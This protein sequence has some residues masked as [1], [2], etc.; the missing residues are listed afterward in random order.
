MRTATPSGVNAQVVTAGRLRDTPVHHAGWTAIHGKN[1][2][3]W[4][5]GFHVRH[6]NG[7]STFVSLS[8]LS[9]LAIGADYYYPYAYI[10]APQPYCE[11][12][13][14]DSCLLMWQPVQTVEGDV[15]YQCVA[16]CP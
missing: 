6:R 4:R 15:I 13:T 12:L 8:A 11:G 3:V 2:S 10:S 14:E 9:A 1:Y 5:G 7:W 16:Y